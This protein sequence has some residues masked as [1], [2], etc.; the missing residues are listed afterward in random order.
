MMEQVTLPHV[1]RRDAEIFAGYVRVK[2]SYAI[3]FMR[4]TKPTLGLDG[5]RS[6]LCGTEVLCCDAILSFTLF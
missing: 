4:N 3:L 2:A 5:I 6:R 1:R